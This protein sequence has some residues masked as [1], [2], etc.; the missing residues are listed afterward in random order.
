MNDDSSSND[1]DYIDYSVD[2]DDTLTSTYDSFTSS[3]DDETVRRVWLDR[4][5]WRTD[6]ICS[7]K[8][9]QMTDDSAVSALVSMQRYNQN[10]K[11]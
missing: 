10:P 8:Q 7:F 3:S 9:D 11:V 4:R 1:S 5:G 2:E 6:F